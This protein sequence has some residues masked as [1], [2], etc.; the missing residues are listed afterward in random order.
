MIDD[1]DVLLIEDDED[2]RLGC[3]QALE[4]EGVRAAGFSCVEEMP[5]VLPRD[6]CLV[7]VSDEISR[8][9]AFSPECRDDR[10]STAARAARG[11]PASVPQ[12][13]QS[14]CG[15]PESGATAS[16]GHG[17]PRIARSQLAR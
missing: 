6:R 10:S 5:R 14:G 11:H 17:D 1:T 8:Q 2:I 16:E 7:V 4:L 15:S 12:L 13:R 3:L 9:S